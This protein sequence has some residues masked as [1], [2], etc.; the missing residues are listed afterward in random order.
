VPH[1]APPLRVDA[2]AAHVAPRRAAQ[3]D[4]DAL[5]AKMKATETRVAQLEDRR[6]CAPAAR[7]R[8][9]RAARLPRACSRRRAPQVRPA[10]RRRV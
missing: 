4:L 10:G 9:R 6:K 7:A 1:A 8:P 5:V 2:R 3:M